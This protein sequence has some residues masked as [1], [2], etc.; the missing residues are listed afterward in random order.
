MPANL[1]AAVS[2]R[3]ALHRQAPP[4]ESRFSRIAW[5]DIVIALGL[6]TLSLLWEEDVSPEYRAVDTYGVLLIIVQ[7][8]PLALRRRFPTS[9]IA[10]IGL[11]FVVDRLA[12][13][14]AGP[15]TYGALL[16]LHAV[17]TNLPARRARRVGWTVIGGLVGFTA[18]GAIATPD[19]VSWVTVLFMA[20]STIVPYGLGREVHER[21]QLLMELEERAD[22]AEREREARAREAV[23]QERAR[24]AREL[25]D[26]VAHQ[27]AVVTVQAEGASRVAGEVDPRVSQA[28]D[29]IRQSGHDA[30]VE[31][32]RLVGLLRSGEDGG[33]AELEPQPGLDRLDDL[34]RQMKEAG[35]PVTVT[36]EGSP[37]PLP[38]GLDL[39][40]YRIVQESLTNT[41][42][43]GGPDA[44]A[45]VTVR[46]DDTMLTLE[47]ADDGRGAA[48][49][50]ISAVATG[51]G[52]VGM[53]ERVSLHEGEL[54]AGP[55]RG[56]GFSV[57]ARL[58]VGDQ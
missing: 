29:T 4:T 5:F 40:A 38:P 47:V 12:N 58:P 37:Y 43:H 33:A 39:S 15:A 13:Y 35:L 30:L 22:R 45:Q 57:V 53:Q 27:M 24:I 8:L 48:A 41:L 56:G 23:E 51:H 9:T 50:S 52:L 31:M 42:K 3:S 54:T 46:Y 49:D 36:I 34:V 14:P 2:P 19:T 32:R 10:V 21:R 18:L 55:R 6:M 26:V 16:A 7:T 20:V 28:L 44:T 11:A 25:H 1:R 17:G